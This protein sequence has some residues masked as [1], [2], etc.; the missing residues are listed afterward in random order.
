[1]TYDPSNG[2]RYY[3]PI[4]HKFNFGKRIRISFR[5]NI[6]CSPPALSCS[7]SELMHACI[8]LNSNPLTDMSMYACTYLL[9]RIEEDDVCMEKFKK[10]CF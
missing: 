10:I 8:S 5:L 6:F 1:M 2:M 9:K 7:P 4:S 3:S